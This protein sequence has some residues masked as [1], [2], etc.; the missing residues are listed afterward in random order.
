MLIIT[1]YGNTISRHSQSR[2]G[3]SAS[4]V[5]K[6]V[7]A[8]F[9]Y[10]E[11]LALDNPPNLFCRAR[12]LP[13]PRDPVPRKK[14]FRDLCHL[15]SGVTYLSLLLQLPPIEPSPPRGLELCLLALP[16]N[17]PQWGGAAPKALCLLQ[18]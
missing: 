9:G 2:A 10:Q 17:G 14:A 18:W 4:L 16:P 8:P 12:T 6:L 3:H 15:S 13:G 5:A 1:Q 7:E 11:L